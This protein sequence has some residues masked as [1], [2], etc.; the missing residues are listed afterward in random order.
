MRLVLLPL[1]IVATPA[2][3]QIWDGGR[4]AEPRSRARINPEAVTQTREIG[5]IG[6]SIRE[7][8]RRGELT[9]EEARTLR[10][11]A[12][13]LARASQSMSA[14]IGTQQTGAILGLR[15]LVDARRA[16]GRERLGHR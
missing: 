9:R 10:A 11:Q 16:Q 3:A 4:S 7:G 15:G 5:R 1:L 8:V 12:G 14:G 13:A 6:R 2:M